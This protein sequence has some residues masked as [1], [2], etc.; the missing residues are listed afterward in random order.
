M[1]ISCDKPHKKIKPAIV[2][3]AVIAICLII[4]LLYL[5]NRPGSLEILIDMEKTYKRDFQITEEFTYIAHTDG[6]VETQRELK[7]PAVV[8]QDK[9][10]SDIRFIAYAYPLE[11]GGWIYRDNYFQKVLVWC[12]EQVELEI[13]NADKCS[14][15]TSSRPPCLVLENTEEMAQK[16]QDMVVLFTGLCQR[17]EDD[18]TNYKTGR[19]E[20]EGSALGYQIEPGNISDRWLDDTGPF[21][22][23]TPIEK[24][25][26]FLD[27]LEEE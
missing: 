25:Q 16:L 5:K 14:E 23:D 3:L 19:F 21:C 2:L 27:E 7:C 11:G 26:A 1:C 9:Q 18:H 17:S 12:T 6:E 22:Y 4:Y 10:N 15:L 20:V 24:Y 8:L 13:N